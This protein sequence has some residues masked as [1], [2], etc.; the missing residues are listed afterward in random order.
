MGI[1]LLLA[2]LADFARSRG[3]EDLAQY[4]ELAAVTHRAVG[5]D[6]AKFAELTEEIKL[7]VA[8]DRGPTE[9]ERTAVRTRRRELSEQIRAL[10]ET[11]DG[12]G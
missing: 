5:D 12:G 9:A 2:A 4:L 10:G 11:G 8:E 6:K 3:Q 1:Q 7:M